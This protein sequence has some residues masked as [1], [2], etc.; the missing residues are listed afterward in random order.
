MLLQTSVGA[1]VRVPSLDCQL[2]STCRFLAP[3][4]WRLVREEGAAGHQFPTLDAAHQ[5]L[6][7]ADCTCLNVDVAGNAV[8]RDAHRVAE[9]AGMWQLAALGPWAGSCD[10]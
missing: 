7:S 6:A 3:P 1:R 4:W 2:D 8:A 10:F 5:V 9:V